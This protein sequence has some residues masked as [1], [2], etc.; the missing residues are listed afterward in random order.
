LSPPVKLVIGVVAVAILT[1]LWLAPLGQASVIADRL[2]DEARVALADAG[3]GDAELRVARDPVRRLIELRGTYPN[4]VRRRMRETLIALPGVYD[5]VWIDPDP[6]ETA[7]AGAEAIANCQDELSAITA[8]D[9]IQ[10]RSGSPYINPDSARILDRVAQIARDC[11]GVRIEIAGH[12][13]N[14][15]SE[16]INLEM[17]GYRATAVRDALVERGV[18][19]DML[20]TIGMGSREPLGDDPAD[21]ANRRIEFTVSAADQGGA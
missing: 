19:A 15:G 6:A 3:A 10:F 18:A 12:S 2:E 4:E 14:R 13:D 9:R 16:T 5:A 21:P 1:W 11:E 20:R 17:S 8:A 7:S